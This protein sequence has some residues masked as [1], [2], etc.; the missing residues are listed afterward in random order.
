MTNTLKCACEHDDADHETRIF[1]GVAYDDCQVCACCF[2][3][4]WKCI[5]CLDPVFY[6]RKDGLWRHVTT[7]VA[8]VNP[9]P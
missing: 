6:D 7:D 9:E 1:D 3:H 8:C 5:H 4:E 2:L